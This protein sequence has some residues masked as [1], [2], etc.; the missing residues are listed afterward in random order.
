MITQAMDYLTENSFSVYPF[1]DNTDETSATG[2]QQ[3]LPTDV[4]VDA[5]FVT[6]DLRYKRVF[7]Y[8][9]ELGNSATFS[10]QPAF[11]FLFFLAGSDG[12]RITNMEFEIEA[13]TITRF[14]TF[15]YTMLDGSSAIKIV[16]GAGMEKM[17]VDNIAFYSRF[18]NSDE[19]TYLELLPSIVILPQPVVSSIEFLNNWSNSSGQAVATYTGATLIKEGSN[20]S[21]IN[22]DSEHEVI[23]VAPGL[24]TGLY[25]ACSDPVPTLRTVNHKAGSTS[26][27][28]LV[29]PD[30]C[31]MIN[32]GIA[33]I[34]VVHTC[35]PK[36]T[37]NQVTAL[38]YYIN[39]IKDGIVALSGFANTNTDS[40]KNDL[41][42]RMADYQAKLDL[43]Q[44]VKSPYIEVET[45]R[46]ASASKLY[47]S[48][49]VGIYDPNNSEVTVHLNI[50][51]DL[52]IG[53][54]AVNGFTYVRPTAIWRENGND[55]LLPFNETD[56]TTWKTNDRTLTCR[57]SNS[58]LSTYFIPK[59]Q[60]D[61]IL[62]FLLSEINTAPH[63]ITSSKMQ[64]VNPDG[65]YY[66]V[67]TRRSWA[68]SGTPRYVYN[69]TID[70]FKANLSTTPSSNILSTTFNMTLPAGLTYVA[71]SAHITLDKTVSSISGP[72]GN[73][74][75]SLSVDFT[76]KAVIVFEADFVPADYSAEVNQTFAIAA[77][78][79]VP[80]DS[81]SKSATL[82]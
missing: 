4:F 36:C 75:T 45:A 39:R 46:A 31:L 23:N 1:K 25:D 20:I 40:I 15:S 30:N 56:T 69:F 9:M 32:R 49:A 22:T 50:V 41:F 63:P 42:A 78:L 12:V 51:P 47:V 33:S 13:S 14:N 5:M 21:L 64:V 79:A 57:S 7:L 71:S 81:F 34:H 10:G 6:K 72:S 24:G 62:I 28:L 19:G 27:D 16:A 76:K 37:E 60:V 2:L 44:T 18:Y 29:A 58:L 43:Q 54:D 8:S 3:L 67:K 74:I 66:T 26:G 61:R 53:A 55:Y 48:T 77:S 65:V 82:R 38:A 70:L 35:Q 17:A 52:S 73:M 59:T 68:S 80:G 11:K